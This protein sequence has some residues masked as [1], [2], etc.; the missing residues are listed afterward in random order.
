MGFQALI[1]DPPL[2]SSGH[3]ASWSLVSHQEA[4]LE[5]WGTVMVRVSAGFSIE[6][7]LRVS[8]DLLT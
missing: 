8:F 4:I 1:L 6:L 3:A 7:G 5:G 2:I